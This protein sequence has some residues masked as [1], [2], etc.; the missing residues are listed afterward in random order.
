M[1]Q[2]VSQLTFVSARGPCLVSLGHCYRLHLLWSKLNVRLRFECALS[3]YPRVLSIRLLLLPS[4]LLLL[5]LDV[6][7]VERVKPLERGALSGQV[8]LFSFLRRERRTQGLLRKLCLHLVQEVLV[9]RLR[10]GRLESALAV[11]ILVAV[12]AA[13]TTPL[14]MVLIAAG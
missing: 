4:Q 14:M 7:L 2:I 3:L 5:P 9:G 13:V 10:E 8:I 12:Q 6:V 11:L 1:I